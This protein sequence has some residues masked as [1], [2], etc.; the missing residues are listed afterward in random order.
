M[1]NTYRCMFLV[2]KE[3]YEQLQKA[4]GEQ[5]AGKSEGGQEGTSTVRSKDSGEK[6]QINNIDVSHGGTLLINTKSD[7]GEIPN[8]VGDGGNVTASNDTNGGGGGGDRHAVLNIPVPIPVGSQS[9]PPPPPPPPP[10]QTNVLSPT[11]MRLREKQL[12]KELVEDRLAELGGKTVKRKDQSTLTR[13]SIST[14]ADGMGQNREIIHQLGRE[15]AAAR[16][17]ARKTLVA[18]RRRTGDGG[19]D[20]GGGGGGGDGKKSAPPITASHPLTRSIPP[21]TNPIIP[22]TPHSSTISPGPER[23]PRRKVLPPRPDRF[24]SSKFSLPRSKK[25]SK[26]EKI[27]ERMYTAKKLPSKHPRSWTETESTVK[28]RRHLYP[29]LEGHIA[30]FKR[31]HEPEYFYGAPHYVPRRKKEREGKVGMSRVQKRK[32]TSED[33]EEAEEDAWDILPPSKRKPEST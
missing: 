13:T 28:K 19:N 8:I 5:S 29:Y 32:L 18:K 26:S 12:M 16:E 9:T 25:K 24:L 20:A 2:A 17:T 21:S 3:E 6:Q 31:Q 10:P 15:G 11:E 1:P 27:I 30:G 33:W 4:G 7:G 23:E 22:A 14:G